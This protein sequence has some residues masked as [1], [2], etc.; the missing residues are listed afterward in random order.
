MPPY[1]CLFTDA[2][3]EIVLDRDQSAG[4]PVEILVREATSSTICT[5][6]KVIKQKIMHT[7]ELTATSRYMLSAILD[8]Y[9]ISL[10]CL[11]DVL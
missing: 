3:A 11:C 10:R 6:A 1:G 2:P 9:C 4:I 7:I 8:Y 5:V